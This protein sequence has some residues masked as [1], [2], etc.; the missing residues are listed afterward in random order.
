[1]LQ[2]AHVPTVS[3]GAGGIGR[4]FVDQIAAVSAQDSEISVRVAALSALGALAEFSNCYTDF[5]FSQTN[6][7]SVI[8]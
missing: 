3:C 8:C 2:T 1:M 5:V 6:A 4:E 7:R